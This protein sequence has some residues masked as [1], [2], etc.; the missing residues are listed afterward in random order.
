M[1]YCNLI[2]GETIWTPSVYP[3]QGQVILI[4]RN[5]HPFNKKDWKKRR[6]EGYIINL[7]GLQFFSEERI[8]TQT[9]THSIRMSQ[10]ASSVIAPESIFEAIHKLKTNYL[11][12]LYLLC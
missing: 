5:G 11:L 6:E 7:S 9:N 2:I 4:G 10:A 3:L 8:P 12:G 1:Y